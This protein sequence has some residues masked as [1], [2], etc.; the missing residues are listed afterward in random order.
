VYDIPV[1]RG[2]RFAAGM[3]SA[4]NAFVGGWQIAGVSTSVPGE[5][6][7]L[8]YT[9][10]ASFQVSGIQQDFRGANNYRP[11]VT[12]T[13]LVPKGQRTVNNWFDRNSVAIPTDPS[14]PFGNA[15]R[16]S[17]RGPEYWSIDFVA[18]KRFT[19][20]WRESNFEFRAETFNLLNRTNFRAP[21][22]NRS[23]ASFGSITAAYDP[24]IVQFGFKLH[25]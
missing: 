7:T 16:N 3:H 21:N 14:Q 23:A 12:G 10:A 9:P 25:F 20:P 15:A 18:S 6:V 1:G 4:L 19:L 5:Q 2:R 13:V 11:N 24:R 22:G 8:T 17:V